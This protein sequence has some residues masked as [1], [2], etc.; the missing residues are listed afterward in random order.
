[1]TEP[2]PQK[3]NTT[4]A[5]TEKARLR[6]APKFPAFMIVGGGI[7][8]LT[9]FILTNLFP[10]DPAVGFWSL[11][12]YFALYGVPLG[13]VLGALLALILDR[14]ASRRSREVEVEVSQGD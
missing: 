12:G 3:A 6:R 10:V 14:V 2:A 13:I 9:T 7:G 4:S 11:F 8:A 5:K 1:M